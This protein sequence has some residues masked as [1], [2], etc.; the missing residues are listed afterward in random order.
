M[1]DVDATRKRRRLM[2]LLFLCFFISERDSLTAVY[3][4]EIEERSIVLP[5]HALRRLG[6]FDMVPRSLETQR[7]EYSPDGRFIATAAFRVMGCTNPKIDIWERE[8]GKNVTPLPLQSLNVTGVSWAPAGQRL[9]TSHHDIDQSNGHNGL[10]LWTIGSNQQK[11]LGDAN[12]GYYSVIWSPTGDRIAARSQK[13]SE[14]VIFKPEGEL[15]SQF[16]FSGIERS[17]AISRI[18]DFTPDGQ[19]L[20]VVT[21]KGVAFHNVKSGVVSREIALEKAGHL[22]S[23]RFLSNPRVLVLGTAHGVQLHPLEI[24]NTPVTS[25]GDTFIY[26]IG[27]SHDQTWLV[28]TNRARTFDVWNLKTGMHSLTGASTDSAIWSAA[29]APDKSE[30][31]LGT[32]RISFLDS[33][34][35]KPVR[36]E[37]EHHGNLGAGLVSGSTIWFGEFGPTLREWD[38]ERGTALKSIRR[39]AGMTCTFTKLDNKHLAVA[40]NSSEIEVRDIKTGVLAYTL[41]GHTSATQTLA[42][43]AKHQCLLSSGADGLIR[44]WNLESKKIDYQFRIADGPD[45]VVW[46]QLFVAPDGEAFIFTDL[47]RS[48]VRSFS[49]ATGEQLWTLPVGDKPIFRSPVAFTPD[50]LR[51]ATIVQNVQNET[52]NPNYSVRVVDAKTSVE[53]SRFKCLANTIL[54]LAI[55]PDGK[56]AAV[57]TVRAESEIEIWSIEMNKLVGILESGAP[58][59]TSIHFSS[60]SKK[61]VTLSN[62]T[63]GIVWDV[64]AAI[65]EGAVVRSK[66]SQ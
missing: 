12:V 3:S 25:L 65:R 31:A 44:R 59:V 55:S 52:E 46:P 27:I 41:P 8:T 32:T 56:Y 34:T 2:V 7:I 58:L 24:S 64:Q 23:I 36:N 45:D 66:S 26:E 4:F 13:S 20:A 6:S 37:D 17:M 43:S 30:L 19:E 22:T 51:V 53:L 50:S 47:K 63:T 62:D 14:V 29:F 48:E 61:L 5:K 10:L 60:D 49:V 15:V 54:A 39:T 1:N 33:G 18:L 11:S 28:A 16:P 57:A 38:Y 9:V 21:N 40:G 35:W 42:Y